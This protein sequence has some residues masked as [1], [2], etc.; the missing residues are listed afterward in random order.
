MNLRDGLQSRRLLYL[1]G[2]DV[3]IGLLVA[4][5]FWPL[6]PSL[7]QPRLSSRISVSLIDSTVYGLCFG[8]TMPYLG[9]RLALLRT[10]W[11][12]LA[13]IAALLL[14]APASSLVAELSLLGLGLLKVENFW[15]EVFYKSLG[16]FFIALIVGIGVYTYE[17][18]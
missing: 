14:L 3:S 18:F 6:Q 8:L 13:I 11:N 9:E 5:L 2:L 17:K 16:V 15:P 12:C 10:P 4:L 1:M 7:Y